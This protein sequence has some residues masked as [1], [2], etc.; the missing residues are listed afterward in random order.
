VATA[1]WAE[2]KDDGKTIEKLNGTISIE[3]K[4]GAPAKEPS[5]I[6]QPPPPKA[7]PPSRK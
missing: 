3:I 6:G 5:S 1:T 7:K 4:F 2:T